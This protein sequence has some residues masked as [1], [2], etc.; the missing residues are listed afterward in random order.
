MDHED[1][2]GGKG[3]VVR[4]VGEDVKL[5]T[6]LVLAL[7][8]HGRRGIDIACRQGIDADEGGGREGDG[9]AVHRSLDPV[10]FHIGREVAQIDIAAIEGVAHRIKLRLS[11]HIHIEHQAV[12]DRGTCRWYH[13]VVVHAHTL[14]GGLG[15]ARP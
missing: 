13:C 7:A 6:H 14:V 4:I 15:I 2:L 9:R 8:H 1:T 5:G 10:A 12:V 3:I 11:L